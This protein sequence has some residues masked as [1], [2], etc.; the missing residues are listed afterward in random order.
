MTLSRVN[1]AHR[2]Y[3]RQAT[4]AGISTGRY[5]LKSFQH[6]ISNLV[7]DY[8]GQR[9]S[10]GQRTA[11]T[12]YRTSIIFLMRHRRFLQGH[13]FFFEQ[14]YVFLARLSVFRF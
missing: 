3:R 9:L 8:G 14:L 10:G 5:T 4:S 2:S 11:G 1:R 12:T 7:R 6:R 13:H